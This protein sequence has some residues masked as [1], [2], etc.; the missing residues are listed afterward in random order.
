LVIPYVGYLSPA[1]WGL[2]GPVFIIFAISAIALIF[3]VKNLLK[4]SKK[5]PTE[6][7]A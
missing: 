1:L 7:N 6:E 4:K 5:A 2:S 3:V